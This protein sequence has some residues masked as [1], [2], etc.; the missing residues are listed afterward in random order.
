VRPLGSAQRTLLAKLSKHCDRGGS[1]AFDPGA[2]GARRV[3]MGLVERGLAM[4]AME[5]PGWRITHLGIVVHDGTE[6]TAEVEADYRRRDAK[7]AAPKPRERPERGPG[8]PAS[9][10]WY[11]TPNESRHRKG[12]ELTITD[13]VRARLEQLA[14]ARGVSKSEIVS[15]LILSAK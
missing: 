2:P 12:L 15:G 10:P 13:E 9:S 6:L 14:A 11:S 3:L 5:P 8:N 1:V 4:G 7:R